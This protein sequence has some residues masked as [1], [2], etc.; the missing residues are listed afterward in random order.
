[1]M[2]TQLKKSITWVQGTALTIGAVLGAGIL[3]LPAI[4]AQLAGPA[5]LVSWIAMGLISV[6]MVVA[7]G[8]MSSRYP[9]SG[10]LAAYVRQAFGDRASEITGLLILSAMPF[11]MPLTALVGAHYLGNV[12]GWGAGAIHLAAAALIL[13]AILLN[14]RGIELSGKSQ[15][16]VVSVI[17]FI[18]VFVVIAAAPTL[19][20][21]NFK[22]FAPR[23]WLPVGE[24]MMLLFFAFIGWEM[25]G[26]LAEEFRNP[27]VDLP[28]SLG[29]SLVIVATIYVA[30]SFVI[31]GNGLYLDTTPSGAMLGLIA[32]S[33]GDSAATAVALL[34]F[35][36][37]YCPVHTF[38]A[39][40]SRLVYAQAR[41]GEFPERFAQL[42]P[43]FQTPHRALLSFIPV[44]FGILSFSYLF[45]WDLN[46]LIGIPSSVFL[47]VYTAGMFAAF[48]ILPTPFGRCCAAVSALASLVLF[49]FAGI[50]ILYPIIVTILV[51]LRQKKEIA[52]RMANS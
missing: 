46:T 26:H 43:R 24:T 4:A 15:V 33:M 21:E 23:G 44:F 18:L 52:H 48:Y 42:H 2:Q 12:F 10:G 36:I 3:V 7:I 37:C 17:L 25:V 16:L 35:L 6:P 39:G 11:G 49:L 5:S 40:F 29:I 47:L 50:Y 1:M 20:S 27:K 14:Y 22:P 13:I 28:L 30:I 32:R 45:H 19:S 31:V 41:A 51:W 38:I 8:A 34:G 9:D